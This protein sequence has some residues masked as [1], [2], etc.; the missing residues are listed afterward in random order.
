MKKEYLLKYHQPK[1]TYI[2]F[3]HVLVPRISHTAHP[4]T[5]GL[6]SPSRAQK[7]SITLLGSWLTLPHPVV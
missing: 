1:V 2:T 7:G 6:G 3:V 4:G 5:R